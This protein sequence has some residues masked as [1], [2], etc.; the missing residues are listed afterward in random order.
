MT[1]DVS[2]MVLVMLDRRVE[3]CGELVEFV[4]EVGE[5]IL[6]FFL[7]FPG[8]FGVGFHLIP[9]FGEVLAVLHLGFHIES[10]ISDRAVLEASIHV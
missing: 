9:E 1:K 4:V 8:F 5:G 2:S 7:F 6:F 10:Y 3:L